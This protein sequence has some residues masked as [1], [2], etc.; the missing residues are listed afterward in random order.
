MRLASGERSL[1]ETTLTFTDAAGKIT[2]TRPNG[3]PAIY[4]TGA[5]LS[6]A[7]E[8]QAFDDAYDGKIGE[9]PIPN[10]RPKLVAVKASADDAV[11]E[12][13]IRPK[14]VTGHRER[15]AREMWRIFRTVVG[16]PLRDCDR[17][18]FAPHARRLEL[19]TLRRDEWITLPGFAWRLF[20]LI[21]ATKLLKCVITVANGR[22]ENQQMTW[23]C[24]SCQGFHSQC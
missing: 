1:H 2:G 13:Y 18:R 7:R 20:S 10:G 8:F 14:N 15:E 9:G 4:L 11:M 21:A 23:S 22:L 16:K 6:A 24:C 3:G 12:T 17:L 5:P 19:Y